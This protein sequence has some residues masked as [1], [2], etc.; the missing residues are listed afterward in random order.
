MVLIWIGI[1]IGVLL[2]I[3]L[4]LKVSKTNPREIAGIKTHCAKCGLR[5]KGSECPRCKS[6]SFGV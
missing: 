1:A 2:A 5:T 3:V 4:I 6:K